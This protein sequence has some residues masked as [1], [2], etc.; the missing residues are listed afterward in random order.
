M[1]LHTRE[2]RFDGGVVVSSAV[3][4]SRPLADADRPVDLDAARAIFSETVLGTDN[5]EVEF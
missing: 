4:R 5:M 2:R 1:T 3:S